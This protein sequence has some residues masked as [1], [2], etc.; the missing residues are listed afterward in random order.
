MGLDNVT[1]EPA[2][3]D[4][5]VS[6]STISTVITKLT[7][8]LVSE[9]TTEQVIPNSTNSTHQPLIFL[10]TKAAQGIGGAFAVAAILITCHQVGAADLW[11]SLLVYFPALL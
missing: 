5:S 4:I 6:S 1:T 9:A 11:L 3:G 10:Q 8:T 7:T 2:G